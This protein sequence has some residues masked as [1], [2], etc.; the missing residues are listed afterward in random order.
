[1]LLCLGESEE[2]GGKEHAATAHSLVGI[3][4]SHLAVGIRDK[5]EAKTAKGLD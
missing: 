4:G 3:G 1:V 5:D 2:Q